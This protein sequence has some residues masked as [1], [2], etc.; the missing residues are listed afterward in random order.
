MVKNAMLFPGQGAQYPGMGKD[1]CNAFPEADEIFRRANKALDMDL[2]A[3][4]FDGSIEEVSRTDIGQPAILTTSIAI[5][6]VL[7]KR[8]GLKPK[9]FSATSGLS[10][11]DYSALVFARALNFDDAVRLVAKR[12]RYMQEDSDRNPSGM[13][14]LIGATPKQARSLCEQF[15]ENDVLV[16][17]NFLSPGQIAI[18]GSLE[19]LDQ[20]EAHLKDFGIRKGVRLRVAGAF[21]SPL[22]E[23]G[24]R[25]LANELGQVEF[26]KP[27]VPFASNVTGSFIDDPEEIRA[28]LA[29][30][31]T[32][33][34]LWH[35]IMNT[36]IAKGVDTFFEP[37]P[38][39][40]LTG[41][42]K[43]INRNLFVHNL[44]DPGGI[45]TFV[46]GYRKE[47]S[48]RTPGTHEVSFF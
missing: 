20:A 28:S 18:S 37:G 32:A 11:G 30:Q 22:M 24:G 17:A 43:K 15:G 35:D 5:V 38:G 9:N 29:Q 44:D 36:F 47:A 34:V 19:A 4:C 46:A 25:K 27:I 23:E 26:R 48:F 3:I 21:H 42:L 2:A 41:I 7:E 39:K 12:G 1:F 14:S 31:V 8:F 10:L 6:N 16:P 33:P 13:M 45:D 40:V